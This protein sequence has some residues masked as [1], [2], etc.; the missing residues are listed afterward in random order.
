MSEEKRVVEGYEL[1]HSMY[2]GRREVVLGENKD[3]PRGTDERYIC[4]YCKIQLGYM[5]VTDVIGSDSFPEVA[6]I[7]G[8]RVTEEANAILK[9]VQERKDVGISVDPIPANQ[10]IPLTWDTDLEGKVVVLKPQ[11]LSPSFRRADCQ[12][13]LVWGGFGAQPNARGRTVN[14][15]ELYTGE[16]AN[17][18]RNDV[19]GVI[20]PDCMPEWA[21]QRL[22]EIQAQREATREQRR[23][24]QRSAR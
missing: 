18:Q 5:L 13:Q 11:A 21:K 17:F 19:A 14:C 16:R 6:Q 20:K 24:E 7:F 12:L 10:Y 1:T 3:K 9:E 15:T 2:I 22:Q 4:G 8:Q 23:N